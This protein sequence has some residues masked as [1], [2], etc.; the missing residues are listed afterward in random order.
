[1]ALAGSAGHCG[2]QREHETLGCAWH[3][4][5][6]LDVKRLYLDVKMISFVARMC[7]TL[8]IQDQ[9]TWGRIPAKGVRPRKH[10]ERCA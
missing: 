5:V 1:M 9:K 3:H 6:Y 7:S 4:G 8:E 2:I 10:F